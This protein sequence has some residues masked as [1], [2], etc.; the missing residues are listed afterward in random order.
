[1]AESLGC[2]SQKNGKGAMEARWKRGEV[3]VKA[4]AADN[5]KIRLHSMQRR[6]ENPGTLGRQYD[7]GAG[8]EIPIRSI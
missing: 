8:P 7:G 5:R 3:E 2:K 4:Q 6:G 1:M